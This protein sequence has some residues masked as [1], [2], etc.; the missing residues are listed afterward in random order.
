LFSNEKLEASLF[1]AGDNLTLF[2]LIR[3]LFI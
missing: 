2:F 3:F 1:C